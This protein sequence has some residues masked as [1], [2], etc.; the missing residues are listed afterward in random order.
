MCMWV[1]AEPVEF[2]GMLD[3]GIITIYFY[4]YFS[5]KLLQ[6]KSSLLTYHYEVNVA[7][8]NSYRTMIF[9]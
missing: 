1:A 8:R 4:F 7:Q 6:E 2:M 9:P 3:D 5:A